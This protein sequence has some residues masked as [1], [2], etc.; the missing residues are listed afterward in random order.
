MQTRLIT[1]LIL[2]LTSCSPRLIPVPDPTRIAKSTPPPGTTSPEFATPNRIDA[3]TT[4][5][6]ERVPPIQVIT[7]ITGEVRAELLDSILKDLSERTGTT[8]EQF[9]VI[10]VQ[11]TVWNDGSLGCPQPG[12]FY[13]QA[14]VNGYWVIFEIDGKKFDYRVTDKGYFF[15][16]EDGIFPISP[17]D[18]PRS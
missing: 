18:T 5:M 6:P 8:S 17:P 3:S 7:P 11:E 12:I 9:S 14:L 2:L 13:T 10:Q 1:L 16:C 4:I 15:L